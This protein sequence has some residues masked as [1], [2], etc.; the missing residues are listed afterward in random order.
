[1]PYHAWKD[2]ADELGDP[3]RLFGVNQLSASGV[4]T[5]EHGWVRLEVLGRIE[6]SR[7]WPSAPLEVA[8]DGT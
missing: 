6:C 7:L 3:S 2:D 5:F 8:A 1:V 4:G